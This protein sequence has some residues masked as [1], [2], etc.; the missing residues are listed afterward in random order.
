MGSIIN[1]F[2]GLFGL[3]LSSIDDKFRVMCANAKK[4]WLSEEKLLRVLDG[5]LP[6]KFLKSKS[7]LSSEIRGKMVAKFQELYASETEYP[8]F[9]Y[10]LG[11]VAK[12][13]L[14]RKYKIK[15]LD[16]FTSVLFDNYIHD[17]MQS[18][19]FTDETKS[20]SEKAG[21]LAKDTFEIISGDNEYVKSDLSSKKISKENKDDIIQS[22]YHKF[23][24]DI[25]LL[26]KRVESE[27]SSIG[28]KYFVSMNKSLEKFFDEKIL[29]TIL[30]IEFNS[31][32]NQ[33]F[34]I[35]SLDQDG[36]YILNNENIFNILIILRK[37]VVPGFLEHHFNYELQ[38][39]TKSVLLI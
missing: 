1:F 11:F 23:I 29:G 28:P 26:L 8:L 5:M 24:N 16:M 13:N 3:G 32:V 19:L 6:E 20:L 12:M 37:M 38:G 30:Q 17:K 34:K 31:K 9:E 35:I 4:D 39:N 2:K 18:D 14:L 22:Q 33:K 10:V 21:E 36:E 25:S 15:E 7:E 27:I